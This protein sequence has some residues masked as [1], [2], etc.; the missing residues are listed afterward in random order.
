MTLDRAA[1]IESF[2][3]SGAAAARPGNEALTTPL[4]AIEEAAFHR[5]YEQLAPA[6]RAYVLRICGEADLADDVVQ[7]AFVKY[8]RTPIREMD[9]A[10]T[11][12]VPLPHRDKS[13]NRPLAPPRT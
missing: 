4:Q 10:A 11:Q 5:L 2:I 13:G 6:L 9:E 3:S 7:D 8:L 12:G 1:M